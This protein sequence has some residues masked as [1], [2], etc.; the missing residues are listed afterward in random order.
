MSSQVLYM[1]HEVIDSCA[2]FEP[3]FSIIRSQWTRLNQFFTSF[4]NC[5]LTM[6]WWPMEICVVEE[7]QVEKAA[8]QNAATIHQVTNLSICLRTLNELWKKCE[9]GSAGCK[10]AKNFTAQE[11]GFDKQKKIAK[12]IRAGYTVDR[13]IYKVYR[14]YEACQSVTRILNYIKRDKRNGGHP[15]LRNCSE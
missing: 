12:M 15:S 10:P 11:R 3:K 7:K 8:P 6:I 13:A 9:F 14:C 4:S 5:P 2:V 1:R